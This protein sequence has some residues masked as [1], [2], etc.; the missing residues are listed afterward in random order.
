[1]QSLVTRSAENSLSCC[2][3]ML[4]IAYVVSRNQVAVAC[5]DFMT[6]YHHH[7]KE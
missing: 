3:L 5:L 6:F 2:V 4:N 1:M 7:I